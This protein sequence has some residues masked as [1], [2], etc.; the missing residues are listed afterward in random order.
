MPGRL[1]SAFLAVV[2]AALVSSAAP[3]PPVAFLKDIPAAQK[4]AKNLRIPSYVVLTKAKATAVP[5]AGD[6]RVARLAKEFA[7]ASVPLTAA[8]TKQYDLDGDAHVLLLDPDGAVL[9]KFGSDATPENLV[10]AMK[11]RVADA[12]AELRKSAGPEADAK[13]RKAAVTGLIR[14]GPVAEDLVPFL[15][16]SDTAVKEAARKALAAMPPEAST[17]ALMDAL[18]SDEAALRTAA[19]PLAVHATGYKGAPLKMWQSGTAEDRTAAWDKWNDAVEKQFPP[20]N[21]AVLAYAEFSLGAQ[22]TNGEC[23]SLASEA[24]KECKAKPM[25]ISGKT[26]I[27]GREVKSGEPVLP[28]DVIQFEGVKFANGAAPHH[29]AV[30]R[31]VLGPGRYETLE[32]NV[33]GVKKVQPGKLD[34]VTVKEGTIVIFRP[35][36]K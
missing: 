33:N 21:R 15:T 27:W 19:H 2:V 22:V 3:P 36:P 17:G 34:M 25:V 24:F 4:E 28:G 8:L 14:L 5:A 35:Q 16:D 1:L 20:L 30:V 29:T 13:A 18:K 9:D 12:R 7:C 31:K 10:A 23:S 6:A 11:A 26:Y 32:Q